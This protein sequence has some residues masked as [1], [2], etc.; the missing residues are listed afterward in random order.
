M[1]ENP[2]SFFIYYL[3][4][5]VIKKAGTIRPIKKLLIL[6]SIL[7]KEKQLSSQKI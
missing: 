3:Y 5:I 4:R 6:N 2:Y 1:I 7:A